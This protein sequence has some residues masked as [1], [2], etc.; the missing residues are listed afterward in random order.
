MAINHWPKHERPRER[1][2]KAGAYALSDAELLAIFLRTGIPGRSAVELARDLLKHFGGLHKL[3]SASLESFCEFPGMG[4]AKYCQL[5]AAIEMSKRC[6][7]EKLETADTLNTPS[8]LF[9]FVQNE[10]GLSS[11]EKFL[12]IALDSHL[13]VI[14][15]Q[16]ISQGT[17]NKAAVYPR[18]VAKFALDQHASRVMIA[19]NHPSGHCH[20]SVADDQLTHTLK[21]ALNTLEIDLVDHVIVS[22]SDYYSY[23]TQGRSPF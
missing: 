9:Q 23:A 3:A 21:A 19:H 15:Q 8:L 1:L 13:K 2:L 7:Q 17:V 18:E 6:F 14:K 5:S 12:V 10:I 20:P 16:V 22:K 11:T 4:P